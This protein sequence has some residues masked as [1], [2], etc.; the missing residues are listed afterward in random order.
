VEAWDLG[1]DGALEARSDA[2]PRIA[3]DITPFVVD[4]D[5]LSDGV[6]LLQFSVDLPSSRIGPWRQRCHQQRRT[7]NEPR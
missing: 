1:A 7:L 4:L 5:T 2:Q 3:G 6:D